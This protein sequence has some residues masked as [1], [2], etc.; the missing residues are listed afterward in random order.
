MAMH[1]F[2][3]GIMT[4]QHLLRGILYTFLHRINRMDYQEMLS[5]ALGL[6]NGWEEKRLI[7]LA[8]EWFITSDLPLLEAVGYPVVVN[9]DIILKRI[10]RKR[11]WDIM[12]FKK[13]LGDRDIDS[14]SNK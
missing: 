6:F 7:K 5:G 14:I 11:G 10:A 8:E 9:P 1:L 3:N 2:R 13:L 4:P 12:H